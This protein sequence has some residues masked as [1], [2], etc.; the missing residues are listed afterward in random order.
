MKV[1][2]MIKEY[3]EEAFD[4]QIVEVFLARRPAWL[5]RGACWSLF[6]GNCLRNLEIN[7]RQLMASYKALTPSSPVR[8]LITF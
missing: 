7:L 5:L 1:V 3:K 4:E 2:E 8:T 6:R